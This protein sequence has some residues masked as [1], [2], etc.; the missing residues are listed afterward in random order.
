[1]WRLPPIFFQLHYMRYFDNNRLISGYHGCS[2][3]CSIY[4]VDN[5]TSINFDN[6][7][8][9]IQIRILNFLEFHFSTDK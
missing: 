6:S 7:S 5:I 9:S 8:E 2:I 3:Y 1:M 4:R